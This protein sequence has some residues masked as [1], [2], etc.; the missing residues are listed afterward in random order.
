MV[1]E[2]NKIY[3]VTIVRLGAKGV[4]VEMSDHT[5]EFIHISKLDDDFVSNV[6]A[7]GSVGQTWK[8]VGIFN[9]KTNRIELSRR[10]SDINVAEG[11]YD[12][13]QFFTR[14]PKN[15]KPY[16]RNTKSLYNTS[17]KSL[18]DMIADANRSLADKRKHKDGP[19]P[20]PRKR[21]R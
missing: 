2:E 14:P 6:A 15:P 18:D 9:K 10:P 8:V 3:A 16:Q 19:Q 12:A 13:T 5:T 1:L 4:V 17:S 11:V 20:R 21:K 7:Y